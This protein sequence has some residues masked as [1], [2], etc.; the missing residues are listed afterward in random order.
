MHSA[1]VFLCTGDIAVAVVLD[2][3]LAILAV[4]EEL[5]RTRELRPDKTLL[6]I[7]FPGI[8]I[9]AELATIGVHAG[10]RWGMGAIIA[11]ITHIIRIFILLGVSFLRAVVAGVSAMRVAA[12]RFTEEQAVVITFVSLVIIGFFPAVVVSVDY[13]ISILIA[14]V[15]GAEIQAAIGCALICP[16]TA[17]MVACVADPIIQ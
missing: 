11:C 14:G 7:D 12:I 4:I 5:R 1:V 6:M 16:I 8:R 13:S 3:H 15:D 9:Y 10:K 2:K 17:C